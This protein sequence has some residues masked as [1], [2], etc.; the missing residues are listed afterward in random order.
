MNAARM[1][2]DQPRQGIIHGHDSVARDAAFRI[3]YQLDQNAHDTRIQFAIANILQ[4]EVL[5]RQR[6]CEGFPARALRRWSISGG[7]QLKSSRDVVAM[8]IDDLGLIGH[9]FSARWL[10]VLCERRWETQARNRGGACQ[11]SNSLNEFPPIGFGAP[12]PLCKDR[13]RF[14]RVGHWALQC[15]RR[16]W[17]LSDDATF[18]KR[19]SPGRRAGSAW[20]KCLGLAG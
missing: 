18:R 15:R 5:V 16:G 1:P 8:K 12:R 3:G 17:T 13:R 10:D 11:N 4:Q 19:P 6:T 9:G 7:G 14:G 20:A 2:R